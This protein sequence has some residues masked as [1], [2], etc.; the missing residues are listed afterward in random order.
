M[1]T[2]PIT[3][4]ALVPE[5]P[6]QRDGSSNPIRRFHLARV[7]VSPRSAMGE[8]RHERMERVV[9]READRPGAE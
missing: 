6:E 5:Q 4:Y 2:P 8:D 9:E 3:R 7:S 1:A